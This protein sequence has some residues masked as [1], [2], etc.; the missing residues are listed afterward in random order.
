LRSVASQS[1]GFSLDQ[2]DDESLLYKLDSQIRRAGGLVS[3]VDRVL[4]SEAERQAFIEALCTHETRF[5]RHESHFKYLN[6][7]FLPT[8][9]ESMLAGGRARRVRAWSVACSTGE[10]P[11]SIAAALHQAFSDD[12]EISVLGTDISLGALARAQQLRWPI[13][14]ASNVPEPIRLRYFLRGV[15]K[16]AGF[17]RPVPE[18]RRLL[19]F[20]QANLLE[21]QRWQGRRFEL[22]FCRNVL[23]Y[24]ARD[25]R[26]RV[27]NTLLEMLTPDGLLVTG[28][29]EGVSHAASSAEMLAPHIYRRKASP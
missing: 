3:F 20:E 22:I 12:V 1:S 17:V 18:I 2:V 24:F 21:L 7:E 8:L 27:A 28:P 5:F 11:T 13:E 23:I 6:E 25:V 19:S 4:E 26:A 16:E 29:S 10:E 15:G 14:F 9:R